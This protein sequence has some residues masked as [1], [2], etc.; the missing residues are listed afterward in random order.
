MKYECQ[1]LSWRQ[2]GDFIDQRAAN[3]VFEE[4]LERALQVDVL[5][6][7]DCANGTGLRTGISHGGNAT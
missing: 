5:M 7:V 3:R 4:L 6:V 2:I 1:F